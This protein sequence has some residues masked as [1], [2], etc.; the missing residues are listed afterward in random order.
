[1]RRAVLVLA[2][3]LA[4]A[5]SCPAETEFEVMLKPYTPEF[6]EWLDVYLQSSYRGGDSYLIG[7]RRLLTSTG[8]FIVHFDVFVERGEIGLGFL[9][10][11]LPL[12][13]ENLRKQCKTWTS[14]GYPIDL[15]ADF[16]FNV[17]FLDD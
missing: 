11:V 9:Y 13:K 10:R 5:A 17:Q 4:A 6:G 3:L 2:C 16:V 1:M 15:D 14:R 8:G 7:I 12:W